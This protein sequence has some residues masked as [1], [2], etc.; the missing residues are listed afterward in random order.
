MVS[1]RRV[2]AAVIAIEHQ[3]DGRVGEVATVNTEGAIGERDTDSIA[4]HDLLVGVGEVG[5]NDL[6]RLDLTNCCS[7]YSRNGSAHSVRGCATGR[8]GGQ[9]GGYA[10]ATDHHQHED[11]ESQ[12]LINAQGR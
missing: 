5:I 6:V 1:A 3:W 10:A 8:E 12:E 9:S 11:E 7:N 4:G 2:C